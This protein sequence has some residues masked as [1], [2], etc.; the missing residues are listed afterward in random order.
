MKPNHYKQ[1]KSWADA[2][3]KGCIK[4][5]DIE[6]E[7]EFVWVE[8]ADGWRDIE[9]DVIT[10]HCHFQNSDNAWQEALEDLQSKW[11]CLAQIK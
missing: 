8:L 10:L 5:I 3:R 6:W 11:T 2:L 7:N 4:S 9:S 1:P